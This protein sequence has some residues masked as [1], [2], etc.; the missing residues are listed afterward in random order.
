MGKRVQGMEV[1]NFTLLFISN[2]TELTQSFG[3]TNYYSWDK[4][5]DV[6]DAHWNKITKTSQYFT[7]SESRNTK[8]CLDMMI[9]KIF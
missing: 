2:N 5:R 3:L 8:L 7:G 4:L 6:K 1:N 9:L